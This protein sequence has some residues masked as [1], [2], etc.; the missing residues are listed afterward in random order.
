MRSRVELTN[1]IL[2]VIENRER[3][4]TVAQ[5]AREHV[6]KSFSKELR[7]SRL[8]LLYTTVLAKRR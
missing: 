8:E 2:D 6:V 3:A 1:A 7:I 4:R 5:N